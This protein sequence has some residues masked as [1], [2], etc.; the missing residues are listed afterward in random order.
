MKFKNMK[1][2]DID[3]IRYNPYTEGQSKSIR[4]SSSNEIKKIVAASSIMNVQLIREKQKEALDRLKAKDS[5]KEYTAREVI[6]EML[7]A[8]NEKVMNSK[9]SFE[10]ITLG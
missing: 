3:K 7:K 8:A 2:K 10:G 1:E 6:E 5:S 9:E 4:K